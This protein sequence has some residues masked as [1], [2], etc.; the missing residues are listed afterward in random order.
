MS[1]NDTLARLRKDRG[2]TQGELA[3][4]LYVTRQAVS[5]WE[6]GET[7]PGIDMV[8]L[9][10]TVLE[11]PIACLLEMPDWPVC[12]SC[13]MPLTD[14]GERATEADGSTSTDFCKHCYN[15]G[16]YTY[17]ATMDELIER[18]APFLVQHGGMTLDEAISFMGAMLPGLKRWH[19]V[20][21]NEEQYGAE[22]R[23]LYGNDVIDA[24]NKKLLAMDEQTWE[25]KEELEQAII[26]VLSALMVSKDISS[27]L[28][29]HLGDMH[30]QWIRMHWPDGTYS[31][32][33]HV[34]LAYGYLADPRFIEYYDSRAGEGATE[35]LVKVIERHCGA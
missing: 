33:A 17:E 12:Q 13:G 29:A 18:C 1:F 10:A 6:N 2:L 34:S 3:A 35:L 15:R 14:L 20:R 27:P 11:V 9:I 5:R 24:S 23:A 26:E 19:A 21:E 32:Q 16:R 25:T 7:T 31:R 22:A 4:K 30:E 28:A 8:K